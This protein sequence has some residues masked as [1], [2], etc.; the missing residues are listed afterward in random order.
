MFSIQIE[1]DFHVHIRFS[2]FQL[3]FTL[4]TVCQKYLFDYAPQFISMVAFCVDK[5]AISENSKI[6][7]R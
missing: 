5:V 2:I 4:V 1:F 3:P 6:I 7:L